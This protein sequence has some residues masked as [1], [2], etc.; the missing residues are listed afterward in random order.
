MNVLSFDFDIIMAPDINLYNPLVGPSK[1]NSRTVEKI[2]EDFPLLKG[3]RADLNHYQK[4][5]TYILDVVKELKV[6]DIRISFSHE[7]IKN[8]LKDCSDVHM[9][10]IDHHHDLGYPQ[11]EEEESEDICTCANWADYY[12]N[13]NTIIDYIWI[14]NGNSNEHPEYK[15]DLRVKSFD[16]GEFD[17]NQLPKMDKIFICLSPEWV[18]EMYHP[19]FYSMLDL[20]NREKNCHLEVY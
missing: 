20:I 16:L 8:V 11:P 10:N 13:D 12:F 15:T 14:K 17:L 18:P 9:Y 19:L 2:M 4:L 6:Q 7:D 5:L 3:C 1:D